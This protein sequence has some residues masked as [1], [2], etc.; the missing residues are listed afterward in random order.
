MGLCVCPRRRISPELLILEQ[1]SFLYL[2]WFSCVAYELK[3]TTELPLQDFNRAWPQCFQSVPPSIWSN[4]DVTVYGR[5]GM[6]ILFHPGSNNCI[7][8]YNFC[9]IM[10]LPSVIF[11]HNH[12]CI[13]LSYWLLPCIYLID[14]WEN[15]T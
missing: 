9:T 5:L 2:P 11:P 4:F 8:P 13:I 7:F 14:W 1:N 6:L 12:K 15:T 10:F 3:S